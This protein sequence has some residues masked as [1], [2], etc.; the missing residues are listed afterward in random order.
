MG[1]QRNCDCA[2]Q[3]VMKARELQA[4]LFALACEDCGALRI[5]LND[6]R[7]WRERR[8]IGPAP[9]P[10]QCVGTPV[11]G[12]LGTRKARICPGCGRPMAR[13]RAGS[14]PDF[15]IDRCASCQLLVLDGGEWEALMQLGALEHLEL[16]ASD[17]WQRCLQAVEVAERRYQSLRQR[18][19]DSTV[20]E[21][22]RIQSWLQGHPQRSELL[23]LLNGDP[24]QVAKPTVPRDA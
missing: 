13:H 14:Q 8:T 9:T 3:P 5:D 22:V 24:I 19:G 16:I 21:L 23:A 18:L 11:A 7:R 20:D 4:G 6:Y 1:S 15:H 2:K 17:H 12:D 10:E